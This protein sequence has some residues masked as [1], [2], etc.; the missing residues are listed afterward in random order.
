MIVNRKY[1]NIILIDYNSRNYRKKFSDNNLKTIYK[2]ENTN[3]D[4]KNLDLR[5]TLNILVIKH[6]QKIK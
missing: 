5:N 1:P 4:N 2:I 3:T 6:S